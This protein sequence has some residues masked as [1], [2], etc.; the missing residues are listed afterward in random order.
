MLRGEVGDDPVVGGDQ[1]DAGH[2][3]QRQAHPLAQALVVPVENEA[4][5][6]AGAVRKEP[7]EQKGPAYGAAT[8]PMASEETPICLTSSS[9]AN[10][11]AEAVD[12]RR[13]GLHVEL[14]AHQQH[15]AED[16]AGEEA[17][18]RGQQNARE[19]HAE[20]GLLRVEAVEPPVHV[21][22]SKDFG[23][24]DGRAQHQVHGGEDDRERALAFGIAALL[25]IAGKDGDE[26]DGCRAADEEIGDHV[27]QDEG[28]VES[29]GLD[30][31]AEEPDD[32]FDPHQPDDAREKSGHHEHDGG[33]E[34]AVP[35][36][37]MEKPAQ[38]LPR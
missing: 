8:V 17:Q 30:A 34:D 2:E 29:V 26:G 7:V 21:P 27:G 23:Q 22:G 36:R 12:E 32:I 3:R 18:L 13:D 11:R 10:D 38:A 37:R 15:R 1:R 14:L 35:V 28:G 5:A 19:Q 33:G 9:A 25:V 24:D 20:R 31:A 16:A 4:V 6:R